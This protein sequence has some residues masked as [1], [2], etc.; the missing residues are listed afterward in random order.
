MAMA[1]GREKI[2]AMKC[3]KCHAENPENTKFCSECG[4][5]IRGHVPDSP[6]SGTC[7][8][9]SEEK[10]PSA[11]RTPSPGLK[12]AV[13]VTRTLETRTEELARGTVFAGRY[14]IIEELGQGGMGKVYRAFD[15]KI[16]E[17]VALKLLKPEI[18]ADRKTIERFRNELKFARKI[19]HAN[20]CGMFDLGEEG[21]TLFISMEYVRGEDLK[22]FIRRAKQ[23]NVGTAIAIARQVAEGLAEAHKLGVIHRDL[24]PHNIMI[25]KEGN[26][27]IMDFGI[28]RT[29]AGAGTT[30][31]GVIIGTPEYMSPEQ[32]EGKAADQ[33]AD[34][35][36]LG[37]IL[38]EMLTGRVPFDGETALSIAMKHK[39]EIPKNPKQFNPDIPDDLS[40]VILKCLEKDKSKRYQSAGEVY[41]ELEK[42]EKG[43]P[44]TERIVP[45]K[46]P[47]TSKEITVKFQLK[48]LF[49]PGLVI[50]AL[51]ITVVIFIWRV[52]PQRGAAPARSAKHSIA[53]LSF[54]D[55]SPKKDYEYLCEGIPETLINALTKINDLY[56]PARAS[57]FWFKGKEQEINEI[58][59]KLNV[60]TVLR[61]SIQVIGDRIRITPQLINVENG[62][63]L[64]S[65]SY[66]RKFED[67]FAIQDE[68]AQEIVRALKIKLLGEKEASL[69]KNYTE[70]PQAYSLY[71]QGRHLWNKRT[72]E[73]LKKAIDYFNQAVALDPKYA[74]AFVGLADCYLMLP[75]YGRSPI[76]EVLPKARAVVSKALEIDKTLAEAHASLATILRYEFDWENAE[77]E[78]KRAIE[79][80]PNYA[81][82]HHWYHILLRFQGRL[83]EATE[84]IER[85]KELDPLSP[86]INTSLG[87]I[88]YLKR[89]YDQAIQQHR[90]TLELNQNFG[91]GRLRL[92][93][94][95][96]QK[97]M[98]EE[99]IAE[100]QKARTLF[101]NSPYGLG[102][103]GNAYALIG[104]KN[105]AIEVLTNLKGLS[106]QGYS[107]NYD[108]AF[109]YCGLGD[110]EMAF[111]WLERAYKEKEEGMMYLKVD[112]C[113]ESLRSDPRHKSLIKR[114]NLE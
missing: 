72:A 89:E 12:D 73:D 82:A 11:P 101:L 110:K 112:P 44:T 29:L 74:L 83:D 42:I 98:F 93:E 2:A 1:P 6:E 13:S 75:Q 107:L 105:K 48:K 7:P 15:K 24:K 46:K 18:A 100:F 14:E 28:A 45:K 86:I 26:A 97:G 55:L 66:D 106:K 65:N 113:W 47:F 91:I 19:R 90:K 3:P 114:M 37:V 8:Q 22:S 30:A 102:N 70:N 27:K 43:I 94:C 50:T 35:Y 60:N 68:I 80:N 63:Y 103:L 20:V 34:I 16:E 9:N 39:G 59:Q 67:V 53:V 36:A 58:G 21:K 33:R 23:L 51:V 32:V 85:A 61:G 5:R 104:E 109:I 54:V 17:E 49:I 81:T 84:E 38:F 77:K 62:S 10:P 69:V 56:V 92:G 78:F 41:A 71:L 79:L 31:E 111:E 57:A 76:K 52:V 99:A 64:W 88:F 4:T 25:D 108:I 87:Y 95:Y 40:G 96:L